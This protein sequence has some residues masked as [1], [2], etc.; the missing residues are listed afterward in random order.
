LPN[1]LTKEKNYTSKSRWRKEASGSI[2]RKEVIPYLVGRGQG[3]GG[4]KQDKDRTLYLR[5]RG[6]SATGRGRHDSLVQKRGKEKTEQTWSCLSKKEIKG[7]KK[8]ILLA[9]ARAGERKTQ[10]I[11]QMLWGS[12]NNIRVVAKK[13]RGSM[14]T[15]RLKKRHQSSPRRRRAFNYGVQA[16][17]INKEAKSQKEK[18]GAMWSVSKGG[19][20]NTGPNKGRR[21]LPTPG[22]TDE[23]DGKARVEGRGEA[24]M[25]GEGITRLG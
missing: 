22:A 19:E 11:S 15:S 9:R 14:K 1:L 23:L 21:A 3:H 4:K 16:R 24:R 7:S 5:G 25:R 6:V 8:G 13:K 18:K 12:K 2:V 10:E 20:S 17:E